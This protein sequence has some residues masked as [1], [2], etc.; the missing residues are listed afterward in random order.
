[1]K[2]E[3]TYIYC[4]ADVFTSRALRQKRKIEQNHVY[5]N[6]TIKKCV[7]NNVNFPKFDTSFYFAHAQ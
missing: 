3:A 4:T 5:K 7:K 6:G 1:M 2:S